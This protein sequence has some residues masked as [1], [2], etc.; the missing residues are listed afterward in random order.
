[1]V[2]EDSLWLLKIVEDCCQ[3]L[4]VVQPSKALTDAATASMSDI[5]FMLDYK[6]FRVFKDG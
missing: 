4:T 2:L 6:H 3:N 1:M 5:Y